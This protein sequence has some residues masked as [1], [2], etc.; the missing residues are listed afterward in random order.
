MLVWQLDHHYFIISK[1]IR[2]KRI[3]NNNIYLG[4]ETSHQSE[5]IRLLKKN[6]LTFYKPKKKLKKRLHFYFRKEKL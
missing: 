3:F 4:P 1:R 6:N 5:L 2:E